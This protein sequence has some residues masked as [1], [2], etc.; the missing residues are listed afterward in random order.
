MKPPHLDAGSLSH[1]KSDQAGFPVEPDIATG[2]RPR[3]LGRSSQAMVG[4]DTKILVVWL[5]ALQDKDTFP[6]G[7]LMFSFSSHLYHIIVLN[8]SF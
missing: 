7:F 8:Y 3:R 1:Q 4:S 5:E 2:G 6:T